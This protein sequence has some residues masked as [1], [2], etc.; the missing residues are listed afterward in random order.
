MVLIVG[1][2]KYIFNDCSNR[3]SI[4]V[5]I[6]GEFLRLIIICSKYLVIGFFLILGFYSIFGEKYYILRYIFYEF[7]VL[8]FDCFEGIYDEM[9][10]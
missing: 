6:Y 3:L 5:N 4:I 1:E 7:R 10:G 8:W 9:V 2:L